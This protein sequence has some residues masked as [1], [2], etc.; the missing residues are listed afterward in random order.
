M[1]GWGFN[2]PT[3]R[4][5]QVRG[6]SFNHNGATSSNFIIA[7]LGM[8]QADLLALR[9]FLY[10]FPTESPPITGQQVTLTSSNQ[11]ASATRLGLLI[12]R[13]LVEVPIP[14]C[15]LVANGVIDN[16]VRGWVMLQDG[17]FQSDRAGDTNA[18]RAELEALLA[19]PGDRLTLMC[20]P[21]GSGSRIGIDRDE[22]GTRNGDEI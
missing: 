18:T 20:T 11:V 5:P 21:W 7:D 14:E 2:S 4:G 10:A 12:E 17:S 22:D 9:A 16:E 15:D 3:A 8:P 1:F 6:F 19:T 13:G